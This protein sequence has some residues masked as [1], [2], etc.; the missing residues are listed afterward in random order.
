MAPLMAV[1]YGARLDSL[2]ETMSQQGVAA[3]WIEPS[4]NLFYLTGL[5]PISLERLCGLVI[6]PSGPL[7][8]VVPELLKDEL[9]ALPFE[10][11]PL[12]W[13]DGEG[14]ETAVGHAL[15]GVAKLSIQGSLP[16]WAWA[17][18]A[19][20]RPGLQIEVNDTLVSRL[21]ERK[22]RAEVDL[23]RKAGKAADDT[24]EW[25]AGLDLATMTE[26]RLARA[27]EI[28]FLELGHAPCPHTLVATGPNT[29]LPHHT[30]SEVPITSGAPLLV[31]LGCSI[32]GYWS[33]ITRVF[34]PTDSGGLLS[35]IYGIVTEAYDAAFAAARAGV[36]CKEVDRAARAVIEEAGYGDAFLHRTGH[37][38]GLE[39][40]EP[41]YLT[42]TNEEPLQAGHV[43]SI[44]PGIYLPGRFGVRY[45]NIVY[46][47]DSGPQKLNE[48]PRIHYLRA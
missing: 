25:I 31:D 24:V 21:R 47:A 16:S 43:F 23:L 48:S 19:G 36:A 18:L 40:H 12:V 22:G 38:V 35:D 29:A 32:E 3:L 26:S 41:P 42:S 10:V 9:A 2:R 13:R 28:H 44:E 34:F 15:E 11:E 7:R 33:D 39:M 6:R 4:V 14:P 5:E 46:L 20:A 30:G 37:G 17:R 8:A 1:D 45:E 27:I